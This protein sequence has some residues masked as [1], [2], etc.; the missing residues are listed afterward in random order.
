MILDQN[1]RISDLGNRVQVLE[2]MQR[3]ARIEKYKPK[4]EQVETLFDEL[5]VIDTF[6]EEGNETLV[7]EHVRKKKSTRQC[8]QVPAGTPVYTN[9]H[10]KDAPSFIIRD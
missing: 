10:T 7:K 8:A 2:E 4:C 6:S 9:D 1:K 3:L 5:E